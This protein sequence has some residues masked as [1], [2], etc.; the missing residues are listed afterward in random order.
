MDIYPAID[1]K[2]GRVVRLSQG[3]AARETVYAED[4]RAQARAFI[5]QG[6]SWLHVVDLDRAFGTGDNLDAVRLVIEQAGK[7]VRVQCGGGFRSLDAI[8]GALEAGAARVVIGTAAI[9]D[10]GLV[11]SA[12]ARHGAGSVAVGLDAR[13][14]MIA[15]RGWTEQSNETVT[16][17]ATRVLGQGVRTLVYTDIARDGMLSGPDFDGCGII[18][19]LGAEVI[20]SGGVASLDDVHRAR[21]ANLA[22]VILGRALYEGRFALRDALDPRP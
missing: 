8:E 10:P 7:A 18:A 15:L 1:L 3:D 16:G 11:E 22:G 4:P 6:A 21:K 5:E 12:L 9:T 13:D 20:L 2:G 19:A 17:A 14:G